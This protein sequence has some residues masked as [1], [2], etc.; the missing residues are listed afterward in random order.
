MSRSF[1]LS[2]THGTKAKAT[3]PL[4]LRE[5]YHFTAVAFL[6]LSARL[7]WTFN[8]QLSHLDFFDSSY[9]P[10]SGAYCQLDVRYRI[11]L[12][13]APTACLIDNAMVHDVHGYTRVKLHFSI[14][15]RPFKLNLLP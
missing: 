14:M 6:S 13:G 12:Y 5:M 8:F 10:K 2:P 1:L 4:F 11:G 7:N 15:L 9:F 3:T